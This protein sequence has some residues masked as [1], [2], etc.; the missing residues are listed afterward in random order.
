MN[1]FHQC[2]GE[3]LFKKDLYLLIIVVVIILCVKVL[4]PAGVSVHHVCAVPVETRRGRVGTTDVG[5]GTR[6]GVSAIPTVPL[7]AKPPF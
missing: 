6:A 7:T 1:Y 4:L 5:A 3:N 2:A